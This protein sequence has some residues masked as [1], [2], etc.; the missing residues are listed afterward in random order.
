MI[1]TNIK[2]SYIV[3]LIMHGKHILIAGDQHNQ[4]IKEFF[5][6][7]YSIPLDSSQQKV[8]PSNIKIPMRKSLSDHINN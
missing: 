6:Q 1:K 4:Q 5:N 3:T 8:F 2:Y 7:K